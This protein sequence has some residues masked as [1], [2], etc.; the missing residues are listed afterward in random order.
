MKLIFFLLLMLSF[1]TGCDIKEKEKRLQQKEL[2]LNQKEQEL[3]MRERTLQAKEDALAER[4]NIL[5]SSTNKLLVDSS[6]LLNTQL[7]GIW[8]AKMNCTETTCPGSAV[9]DIKT[10]QWQIDYQD[11][12]V[13]VRTISG[14]KQ[15]R[16][17]SGAYAGNTLELTLQQNDSTAQATKTLVRLQETGENEMEGQREIIRGEECRIVYALQLKKQ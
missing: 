13:I 15:V 6:I 11:N 8:N 12:K 14:N 1:F 2:E 9:G 7:P 4:E 5:D 17:Y 10:E 16:V 3:L